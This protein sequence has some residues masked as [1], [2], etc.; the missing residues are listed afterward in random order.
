MIKDES[1]FFYTCDGTVL[2]SL[3]EFKTDLKKM[4]TKTYNYHKERGDWSNWVAGVLRKKI[5]AKNLAGVSKT[6]AT[7]LL[8]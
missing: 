1:K 3:A 4:P 6:K 2:R 8:K 7:V 5:L